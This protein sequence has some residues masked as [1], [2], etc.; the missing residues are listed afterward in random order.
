MEYLKI[1]QATKQGWI[2]CPQGGV[3]DASYPKSKLRRGRVQGGGFVTPTLTS[4]G[5]ESLIYIEKIMESSLYYDLL[6]PFVAFAKHAAEEDTYDAFL[7]SI[8]E[9]PQPMWWDDRCAIFNSFRKYLRRPEGKGWCFDFENCRWFR[10][11]KLTPRECFR[12]MDAK[13]ND[14]DKLMKEQENPKKGVMEQIISNSQLY[15]CAGNSIVVAPM[16]LCFKNLFF[17]EQA[18][19]PEGTQLTLF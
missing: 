4:T 13:E 9:N 12:L 2:G 5:N 19:I 6:K 1:P 3:F 11:R 8:I 17:P 16:A 10:I 7:L 18:E 14:I 15:K